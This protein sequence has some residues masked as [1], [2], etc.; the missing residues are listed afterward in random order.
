[1][2]TKYKILFMVELLNKYYS[3]LKCTDFKIVPSAATAH[4]LKNYQMVYKVVGNQL[5]V[6]VKVKVAEVPG[7][8]EE[9]KPFISLDPKTKFLFYLDLQNPHFTTVSNLDTDEL[10]S[11]KRFYFSNVNANKVGTVLNLSEKISSFSALQPYEPGNLVDNGTGTI[12]ECIQSTSG[13]NAPSN[14]D[15][16]CQHDTAQLVSSQD[17]VTVVPRVSRYK[18]N[19]PATS[20]SIEVFG[21]NL[22]N[23]LYDNESTIKNKLITTGKDAIDEVQVDLSELKPGRYKVSVNSTI[24]DVWIDD[25]MVTHSFFGVVELYP[26][27]SS[28]SDFDFLDNQGKVKDIKI[29]DTNTWLK[30]TILFGS[31]MAYWKY[32]A[33]KK[34]VT[35]IEGVAPIES[36]GNVLFLPTPAVGTPK[37]YFTSNKPVPLR[38]TP[39]EFKV[40]LSAS[41]SN[42]PP[43]LPNPN[44]VNSGILSRT[45]PDK[46]YFCT[47]YLNY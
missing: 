16:W 36:V 43:L 24:Y 40:H 28:T 30:Y 31:R 19:V 12:F 8:P 4:L 45:E 27:L 22:A 44:P 14:A 6:L 47:I 25:D 2:T 9:N 32:M 33:T 13:G 41:I 3:D 35:S 20:F 29:G 7:D 1:M 37:E 5:V 42:E 21:Y 11:K 15:F 26:K 34:G 39:W 10:R 38:E 46:N 23:G 17:M 18:T